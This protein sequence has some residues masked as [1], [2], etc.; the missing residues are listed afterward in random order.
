MAVRPGCNLDGSRR[1]PGRNPPRVRASSSPSLARRPAFPLVPIIKPL[2]QGHPTQPGSGEEPTTSPGIN[3]PSSARRP[4]SLLDPIASPSSEGTRR[5]IGGAGGEGPPQPLRRLPSG[6][7]WGSSPLGG[8]NS[9]PRVTRGVD[10]SSFSRPG[11]TAG[12][13][14]NF[15]PGSVARHYAPPGLRAIPTHDSDLA[16]RPPAT[17]PPPANPRN[18]KS[19]ARYLAPKKPP[20][21]QRGT[22]AQPRPPTSGD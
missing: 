15:R 20:H 21:Q 14:L 18:A 10:G 12:W 16:R 22:D 4:A 11:G 3:S 7:P 17:T 9:T 2:E 5:D 8:S 13:L 6:D 19:S 1:G